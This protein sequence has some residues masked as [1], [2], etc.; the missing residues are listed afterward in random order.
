MSSGC[1]CIATVNEDR[2]FEPPLIAEIESIAG[3]IDP[4]SPQFIQLRKQVSQQC[5][6]T[7]TG[8]SLFKKIGQA[9]SDDDIDR[10]L[11]ILEKRLR[12]KD[13]TLDDYLNER[14]IH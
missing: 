13:Q 12:L 5:D 2:I 3:K 8:I 14:T 9:A 7:T 10:G 6:P 11:S 4:K 1:N